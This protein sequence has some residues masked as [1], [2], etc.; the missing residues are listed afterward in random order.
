[1]KSM[2][3]RFA[4]MT[5][6]QIVASYMTLVGMIWAYNETDY[7]IDRDTELNRLRREAKALRYG[8]PRRAE[9]IHAA[10]EAT[11]VA[12]RGKPIIRDGE[13]IEDPVALNDQTETGVRQGVGPPARLPAG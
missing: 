7:F 2:A 12:Y 11:I 5:D 8:D 3:A 13:D 4:E 9:L 1:M 10:I 6:K